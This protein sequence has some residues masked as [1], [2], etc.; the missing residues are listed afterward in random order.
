ML[1]AAIKLRSNA[2]ASTHTKLVSVIFTSI[3]NVKDNRLAPT[4]HALP[5]CN[6]PVRHNL[7]TV[8]CDHGMKIATLRFFVSRM[9]VAC[10]HSESWM[11]WT[12]LA[13]KP[14]ICRQHRSCARCVRNMDHARR[15]TLF[16]IIYHCTRSRDLARLLVERCV[17]P[18]YGMNELKRCM[19]EPPGCG[20]LVVTAATE[21][22]YHVMTTLWEC[23]RTGTYDAPKQFTQSFD[24]RIYRE[25]PK[26]I[27]AVIYLPLYDHFAEIPSIYRIMHADIIPTLSMASNRAC[28]LIL[29]PLVRW[30]ETA[31]IIPYA[32]VVSLS[33]LLKRA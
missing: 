32:P 22:E 9:S 21:D 20:V 14:H 19:L 3:G 5:T 11:S 4:S 29:C 15:C 25:N 12:I 1:W 33:D 2:S 28:L 8:C 7:V 13:T 17:E 6:E 24:W 10:T 23:L 26:I 27:T 31:R 30:R 16:I 18:W